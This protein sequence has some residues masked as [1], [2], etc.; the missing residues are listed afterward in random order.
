MRVESGLSE[1]IE[2]KF[3]LWENEDP[4]VRWKGCINTGQDYQEVVLKHANGALC[5][6]VAMHVWRDKLEGGVPLE[7]D[8]FFISGAGFVIQDLKITS[9]NRKRLV[10]N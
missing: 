5:L 10:L 7:S 1:E 8:C 6:I 4:K 3:S 2:S 9:Q